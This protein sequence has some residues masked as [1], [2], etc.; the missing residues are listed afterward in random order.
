MERGHVTARLRARL[1]ISRVSVMDCSWS[2]VIHCMLLVS[3]RLDFNVSGK[4]R[5]SGELYIQIQYW[6]QQNQVWRVYMMAV[7]TS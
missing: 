1:E 2:R 5:R 7:H 4:S 6:A 3:A